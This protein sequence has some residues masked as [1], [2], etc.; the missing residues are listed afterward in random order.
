MEAALDVEWIFDDSHELVHSDGNP[1][2][3]L[4]CALAR[5]LEGLDARV[6]F[7]PFEEEFNVSWP[8]LRYLHSRCYDKAHDIPGEL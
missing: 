3:G 6:L 2:L 5:A 4:D 1:Y 8:K 7:G